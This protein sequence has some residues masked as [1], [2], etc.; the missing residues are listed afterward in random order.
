MPTIKNK[1][2]KYF[3]ILDLEGTLEITELSSVIIDENHNI[4]DKIQ[5]FCKNYHVP[6]N[7]FRT[8]VNEKYGRFGLSDKFFKECVPFWD[9]LKIYEEWLFK[10]IKN[11]YFLFLTCG[12]WDLAKQIPLQCMNYGINKPSFFSRYVN[13]K[14]LFTRLTNVESKGMDFMLEYYKIKLD[15]NHHCALDDCMNLVKLV[16]HMDNIIN[17][18][19]YD[20]NSYYRIRV[21]KDY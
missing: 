13:I 17:E 3:I 21:K 20:I 9:A 14:E 19:G 11:D 6:E 2:I 5:I 12:N 16:K 1:Y 18:N 7:D 8:Y 10:N 4:I 15:G